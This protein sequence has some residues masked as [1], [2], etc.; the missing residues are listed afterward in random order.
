MNVCFSLLRL[1]RVGAVLRADDG[2]EL[3]V[4]L[5]QS[6]GLPIK[7]SAGKR[8]P[9]RDEKKGEGVLILGRKYRPACLAFKGW[10]GVKQVRA[11]SLFGIKNALSHPPGAPS[12]KPTWTRGVEKGSGARSTM[13][14]TIGRT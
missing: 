8:D 5:Y 3:C 9:V 13:E 14:I 2:E 1:F 11:K 6:K 10:T 4:C 7:S 12:R